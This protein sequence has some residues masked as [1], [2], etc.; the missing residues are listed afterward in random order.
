MGDV[1]DSGQIQNSVAKKK[2]GQR[3]GGKLWSGGRNIIQ[4]EVP[5]V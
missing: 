4:Y 5:K 2:I 1:K 3:K